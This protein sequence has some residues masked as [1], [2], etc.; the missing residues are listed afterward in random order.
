MSEI[1]FLTNDAIS[2]MSAYND[3]Y[4]NYQSCMGAGGG[5]SC[6]LDD[7]MQAYGDFDAAVAVLSQA[8]SAAMGGTGGGVGGTQ[9]VL[10]LYYEKVL[11]LREKVKVQSAEIR[12]MRGKIKQEYSPLTKLELEEN[13]YNAVVYMGAFVSIIAVA[14]MFLFFRSVVRGD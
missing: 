7:V 8:V 3:V 12:Q 6:S 1:R 10:S 5:D 2:K 9:D 4:N 11:P 13:R 14:L